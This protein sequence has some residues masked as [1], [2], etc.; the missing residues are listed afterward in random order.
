MLISLVKFLLLEA[1][2]RVYSLFTLVEGRNKIWIRRQVMDKKK[3]KKMEKWNRKKYGF[4]GK[5]LYVGWLDDIERAILR[6]RVEVKRVYVEDGD[7]REP[8]L[9]MKLGR[10]VEVVRFPVYKTANELCEH[11]AGLG[12]EVGEDVVWSL[13]DGEFILGTDNPAI[14]EVFRHCDGGVIKIESHCGVRVGRKLFLPTGNR[15]APYKE[16]DIYPPKSIWDRVYSIYSLV[17]GDA[18]P[19][20]VRYSYFY[21]GPCRHI[22]SGNNKVIPIIDGDKYKKFHRA[23][24]ERYV[25]KV[26]VHPDKFIAMDSN[27]PADD[28][29]IVLHVEGG[30]SLDCVGYDI[31]PGYVLFSARNSQYCANVREDYIVLIKKGV[32]VIAT[33]DDKWERNVVKFKVCD[34]K[35]EIIESSKSDE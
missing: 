23:Y 27:E 31:F 15:L 18:M 26:R 4:R 13:K 34:D 11:F 10:G 33:Y 6:K 21:D 24:G 9:R 17:D 7:W 5:P 22:A 1:S 14:K 20:F 16:L 12:Y 32:E 8:Y 2:T 19:F 35:I 30:Y 28:D 3:E 29:Y 25:E